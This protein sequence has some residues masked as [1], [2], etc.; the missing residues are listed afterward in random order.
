MAAKT[1]A[2]IAAGTVLSFEDPNKKGT[3]LELNEVTAI[4]SIG[5]QGEFVETTP[6]SATTRTF[7]SGL[8]T[9][10]DKEIVGNDVPGNANQEKFLK[11]ASDN[12]TVNMKAELSNGRTGAFV[13]ALSGW[14]INKPQGTET[15]QWTVYGKQSGDVS[16][17]TKTS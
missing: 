17:T 6:L 10:P 12:A 4:G 3:Y 9:P 7:I 11:L 8:K 2:L 14:Q 5:V 16:W 13:L 1:T 15:L